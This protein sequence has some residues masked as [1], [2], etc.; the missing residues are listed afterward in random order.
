MKLDLGLFLSLSF[1]FLRKKRGWKVFET[2]ER[3]ALFFKLLE[4][5]CNGEYVFYV[6]RVCMHAV[7]FPCQR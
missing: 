2:E 6:S 4:K 3:R 7:H 1:L 5:V